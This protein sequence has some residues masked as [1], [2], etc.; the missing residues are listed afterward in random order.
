MS[1][2]RVLNANSEN[3]IKIS[4][5]LLAS[6]FRN[7]FF[8]LILWESANSFGINK[9]IY[10][11]TD[12]LEW[13]SGEDGGWMS[14]GNLWANISKKPQVD[15]EMRWMDPSSTIWEEEKKAIREESWWG[16]SLMYMFWIINISGK[17]WMLLNV[18]EIYRKGSGSEIDDC[19]LDGGG[20]WIMRI[21]AFGRWFW[22][23]LTGIMGIN[24]LLLELQVL[25]LTLVLKYHVVPSPPRI[26]RL[27]VC[28]HCG[29]E[30]CRKE[31]VGGIAQEWTNIKRLGVV[32]ILVIV[33]LLLLLFLHSFDI[34]LDTEERGMRIKMTTAKMRVGASGG[35][36]SGYL[37]DCVT[38]ES[39]V[40]E[41]WG[42]KRG[43]REIRRD[44]HWDDF[45][46]EEND[47]KIL[48]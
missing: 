15:D 27:T 13:K 18:T 48:E 9:Y 44:C 33:L 20:W 21:K 29:N 39:R 11:R 41:T 22:L 12:W 8:L 3:E 40:G 37:E 5:S 14:E 25:E 34:K 4:S 45:E 42:D 24:L 1:R 38:G 32:K 31:S 17:E 28:S 26:M 16:C 30:K 36:G 10:R 47:L 35:W 19:W 2:F 7:F 6:P 43:Q 46:D 23:W